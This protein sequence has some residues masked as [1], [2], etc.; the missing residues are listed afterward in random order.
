MDSTVASEI[1]NVVFIDQELGF[2]RFLLKKTT[3]C[4]YKIFNYIKYDFSK[5]FGDKIFSP[6]R[7]IL[8]KIYLSYLGK[9]RPRPGC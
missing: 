5:T 8:K 4:K 9:I 2:I 6:G 1:R 7:N 3:N